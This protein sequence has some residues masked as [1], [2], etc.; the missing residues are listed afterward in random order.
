[1]SPS[2]LVALAPGV[3]GAWEPVPTEKLVSG[4]PQTRTT[5]LYANEAE[6]LYV[7]EW[8]A[9]PGKWRLS[10]T[11]WEYMRILEGRCIVEG[12]DGSRLEAGPGACFV[13]EPGFTGTWEVLSDVRK[14]WVI[15]E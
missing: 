8:Q 6:R 11:E 2:R 10:Y 12:D 9:T 15:R 14:S 13:I 3:P 1:M 7:G 4:S 5:L